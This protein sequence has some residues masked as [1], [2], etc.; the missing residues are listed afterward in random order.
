MW[1]RISSLHPPSFSA[2]KWSGTSLDRILIRQFVQQRSEGGFFFLLTMFTEKNKQLI[3]TA[4]GCFRRP[5]ERSWTFFSFFP[6]QL[7]LGLLN[8]IVLYIH[9]KQICP[10]VLNLTPLCSSTAPTLQDRGLCQCFRC[11]EQGGCDW[12]VGEPQISSLSSTSSLTLL[13]LSF[14]EPSFCVFLFFVFF[15]L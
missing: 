15:V 14:P 4:S 13:H 8:N 11:W 9:L 3:I 5:N 7:Q 12:C 6:V 10:S 1:V 2:Q